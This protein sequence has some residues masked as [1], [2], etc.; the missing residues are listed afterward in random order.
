M[1]PA[2]QP[3]CVL[4]RDQAAMNCGRSAGTIEYPARPRISAPHTAGNNGCRRSNRDGPSRTHRAPFRVDCRRSRH[5]RSWLFPLHQS[6]DRSPRQRV[7]AIDHRVARVL[8][9]G[10][11]EQLGRGPIVEVAADKGTWSV[12][13]TSRSCKL[14]LRLSAR[15]QKAD[16]AQ[17]L[18]RLPEPP[19]NGCGLLP[20]S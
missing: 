20:P 1:I 13:G 11:A 5:E 16:V 12:C 3:A 18:S 10:R 17:L 15:C 8:P 4:V 9:L 2:S 6:R 19:H 7:S 14:L